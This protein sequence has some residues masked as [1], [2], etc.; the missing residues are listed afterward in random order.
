MLSTEHR[1]RTGSP[2]LPLRCVN[3]TETPATMADAYRRASH[4]KLLLHRQRFPVSSLV[5]GSP[6]VFCSS[7]DPDVQP[8]F[9]ILLVGL[10][11]SAL[12]FVPMDVS[13]VGGLEFWL[14]RAEDR[15]PAMVST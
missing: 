6:S 3:A 13:P 8:R 15:V 10:P 1:W 12:R 4:Q 11:S 9:D 2:R 14:N 7:D 5:P